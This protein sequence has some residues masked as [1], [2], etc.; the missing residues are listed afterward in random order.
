MKKIRE[1]ILKAG[2]IISLSWGLY[3]FWTRIYRFLRQR[4]YK[5]PVAVRHSLEEL[6]AE[7]R[8]HE[9]KKDTWRE[10]GDAISYPR[11]FEEVG[12]LSK[13]GNDCD[14]FS[15]WCLDAAREGFEDTGLKWMPLGLM[16][17]VWKEGKK[18]SGHN[19]AV[20]VAYDGDV[21]RLAHMSNW[22][23]GHMYWINESVYGGIALDVARA[24]GK[25]LAGWRLTSPDLRKKVACKIYL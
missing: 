3:F 24:M 25:P 6:R 4:K 22:R 10:L 17:V 2:L 21:V 13:L 20:F 7:I 1:F 11:H 8:K 5:G 18:L 23:N 12:H 14:D 19:V 16:S 9:W 15:I